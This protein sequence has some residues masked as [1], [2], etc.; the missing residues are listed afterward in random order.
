MM[1]PAFSSVA[2]DS[3][4]GALTEHCACRAASLPPPLRPEPPRPLFA[5]CGAVLA[6]DVL[7]DVLDVVAV[8]G[9]HGQQVAHRG[10]LLDLLLDEPLHELLGGEVVLLPGD[11]QQTVDLLGD[12]LLLLQG[13]RDRADR[14][15]EGR[16]GGGDAARVRGEGDGEGEGPQEV[17]VAQ[18]A[19]EVSPAAQEAATPAPAERTATPVPFGVGERMRYEV[20]FGAT[21]PTASARATF[22]LKPR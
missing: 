8:A 13:Q 6:G 22:T 4:S 2:A 11:A 16:H 5:G 7:L 1:A 17:E 18:Q 20:R 10:D 9:G 15:G 21:R 19:P 14:V 3:N 12:P